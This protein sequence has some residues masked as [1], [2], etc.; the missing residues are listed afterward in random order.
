MPN[1]IENAIEIYG[2]EQDIRDAEKLLKGPN[3]AL[4]FDKV[5]PM[6]EDIKDT[7]DSELWAEEHWGTKWNAS[8]TD[9]APDPDG[10]N[11]SIIATFMTPWKPPLPVVEELSSRFPDI[12]IKLESRSDDIVEYFEF[13]QGMQVDYDMQNAEDMVDDR[14]MEDQG[15]G[16]LLI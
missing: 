10:E 8:E 11:S 1:W 4:D 9:L 5:I 7:K 12:K 2:S 14:G 15:L 16:E 3:G 6:P 13:K